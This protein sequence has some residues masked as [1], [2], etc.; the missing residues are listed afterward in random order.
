MIMY[1]IE[2]TNVALSLIYESIYMY[3][4]FIF[5]VPQSIETFGKSRARVL[6]EF[7]THR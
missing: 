3:D 7:D 4:H 6:H 2:N 1:D 5:R